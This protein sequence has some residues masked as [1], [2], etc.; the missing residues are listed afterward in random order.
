MAQLSTKLKQKLSVRPLNIEQQKVF[1][2]SNANAFAY[3]L[4][5]E[6]VKIEYKEEKT[7]L[8]L[9]ILSSITFKS[10]GP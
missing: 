1:I 10:S 4:F 3:I 6:C 2:T 9:L 8:F 5:I 7:I